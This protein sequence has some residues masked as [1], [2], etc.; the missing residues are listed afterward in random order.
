[1]KTLS[2]SEIR[3]EFLA[4]FKEKDHTIVRSSSLIPSD[5]P[6]VLLTTAGMQQFK[7]YFLGERKPPH[8]RLTSVQK[9]FRTS[10]IDEVGDPTHT[11][12]FE[13]LGN[14]SIGDYF[15]AEAIA[16][17]WE[18]LTERWKIPTERLW[19]SVFSGE[20]AIPADE[21]AHELWASR[22]VDPR[23]IRRFGTKDNFWG[24][25]GPTGPCGPCSEIHFDLTG[26]PCTRGDACGPN[27]SCNRFFE[28]WNLVFMQYNKLAEDEF[29]PLPGKN[30]DTGMGLE[31]IAMILQGKND[32]FATD[33]FLPLF[34]EIERV[35][36]L[37]PR[38]KEDPETL[39][40]MRILADHVRG[41]TFL[42]S[43]GVLPSNEGRGYV[44]R[45]IVRRALVHARKLGHTEPFLQDLVPTVISMFKNTYPTLEENYTY[46]LKVLG[47]EE[48][49]FLATLDKGL[50][51]V[52]E[53][54]E[55]LRNAGSQTLPGALAFKLY[56]TFGFPLELTSDIAQDNGFRVDIEEFEEC[57][58]AQR[59]K[60]RSSWKGS[61][62][63]VWSAQA[64]GEGQHTEF[65]GYDTLE[66]TSM[67]TL[68][69]VNGS[70]TGIARAGQ[71][72]D[73]IVSQTSFY[74]ES[75]GQ[76]GDQGIIEGQHGSFRVTDTKYAFGETI[77]HRGTVLKGV[78][79]EGEEVVLRVDEHKRSATARNHSCTH[80]LHYALRERLGDHVKQSGSLVA[81]D[82]FRFDFTHFQA[83]RDEELYDVEWLV[84][85]KIRENHPVRT[86]QMSYQQAREQK[87]I[88]LFG[89]KYGDT[90]RVVEM[91]DF[92]RELCGGTHVRR[93][94]DI[95][96][97][98]IVHE[99]SV[100]AGLRRIEAVTGEAAI[101]YIQ[102]MEKEL[103][104]AS[105]LLQARSDGLVSGIERL[106]ERQKLLEKQCQVRQKEHLTETVTRLVATTKKV[107]RFSVVTAQVDED[108]PMLRTL[109]DLVRNRLRSGIV[110][111]GSRA[112]DKA[113][114]L[115]AVTKDVSTTIK[116]GDLIKELAKEI[117]GSGGGKADMAQAGGPLVEKL[118]HALARLE[119][120][121][122]HFQSSLPSSPS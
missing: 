112:N 121:L 26:I 16:F 109:S 113:I 11:T 50:R 97:F 49:R 110:L 71:A 101:R 88:A 79:R 1:M 69:L 61:L 93:T 108:I 122:E 111:L 96:L 22:G 10:D 48:E 54:I 92:S 51:I 70:R 66:L 25:P 14:F 37:D 33:L 21:E 31:R 40:S 67:V 115:L 38:P 105:S 36:R 80:L 57:M 107:G 120:L 81:P 42:V 35:L 118:P 58:A 19:V 20:G 12:F 2:G 62:D 8:P 9:C 100:G 77:V 83:L 32:I 55:A 119:R 13:M 45:R 116:A 73:L 99:S 75:G 23:K 46:I 94:G 18:L 98:K 27:C 3:N 106:L 87:A 41:A 56:D 7:P 52:H 104:K 15:K 43:D 89:E 28:I 53:E 103:R 90:V 84:N 72:A 34:T 5:D 76:V 29:V 117:G 59:I 65:L 82:R 63:T 78:I 64:A 4:F 68:I 44:L 74:P 102:A 30:I 39:R 91:D 24:P 6:S 86:A 47:S 95:G 85:E 114:L 17:A 60:A